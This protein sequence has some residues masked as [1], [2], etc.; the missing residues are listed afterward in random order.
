MTAPDA[1]P[2]AKFENADFVASLADDDL[3]YFLLNVGDA[4]CQL[5]LLPAGA[6]GSARDAIVV[7]VGLSGKLPDLIGDLK[8]PDGSDLVGE[9]RV[10]VASHPHLDHIRGMGEFLRRFK[11]RVDEYWDSGYRQPSSVYFNV[12]RELEDQQDTLTYV[13]PTSGMTRYF[14]RLRLTVL[15][16]SVSLRNQYDSYGIDPNNSSVCIKLEYPVTRAV[17][18]NDKRFLENRNTEQRTTTRIILGADAQMV[19]W[20][21]VLED[22]PDL[23][24]DNSTVWRAL[25]MKNGWTPLRAEIL[26]VPHHC[27][28]NGVT[29]ELAA[30][31]KAQLAL[32]SSK[33]TAS[34]YGFPHALAQG[35]LREAKEAIAQSG[36]PTWTKAD[37]ELGIHY[38]GADDDAGTT[39][40]TIALVV[41]AAS[42]SAAMWRFGDSPS[43][44]VDLTKAR[45]FR[46]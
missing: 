26:K 38:T 4:D 17:E 9:I 27:S 34:S 41:K 40:G 37:H 32:I 12:M 1:V 18:E 20:G 25:G 42:Q 15:A 11:G 24:P 36:L 28:K 35:A 10:V 23:Q 30:M 7:D 16:P 3:V 44:S 46:K 43:S 2:A 8:R 6:P 5:I 39:L 31:V 29:V 13:Q 33:G 22:F 45:R 19:S 14:G 21:R